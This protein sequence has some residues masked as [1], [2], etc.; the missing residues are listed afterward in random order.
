MQQM[1]WSRVFSS[2]HQPVG[3]HT[4]RGHWKAEEYEKFAF[5]ASEAVLD[6]LLPDKE[7]EIWTNIL[8]DS[9][10]YQRKYLIVIN[11]VQH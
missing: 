8:G 11:Q 5:P 6:G 7:F 1:P 3:F 10:G 4:C 2:G 9:D